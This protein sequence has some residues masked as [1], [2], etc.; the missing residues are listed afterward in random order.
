MIMGITLCFY[1]FA[2]RTVSVRALYFWAF[3]P[4]HSFVQAALVTTI[5]HERLEKSRWNLQGI[6]TSSYWWPD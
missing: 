2:T 5:S 4:L 6:F 3:C 1:A